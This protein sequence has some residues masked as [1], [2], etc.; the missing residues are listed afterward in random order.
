[1]MFAKPHQSAPGSWLGRLW[2]RLPGGGVL[3]LVL[4]GAL[5]LSLVACGGSVTRVSTFKAKR[6]IVFGDEYSLLDDSTEE[7]NARHYSINAL[8]D[9]GSTVQCASTS[10]RLWV[11]SLADL[12]GLTFAECN[13]DGVASASINAFMRAAYGA[14]AQDVYDQVVA[15]EEDLQG[16]FS[17][18]DMA[19]VLVGLHDVLEVFTNDD[20]YPTQ[21]DKEAE[22]TARGERVAQAVNRIAGHGTRVLVSTVA[23]VAYTPYAQALGADVQA[24]LKEMTKAFNNGL[25]AALLNDG[26]KIGLLY[27]N[28]LFDTYYK[29]S[30]YEHTEMACDVD[31]RNH[32]VHAA[33]LVQTQGDLLN[34]TTAT[35]SNGASLTTYLWADALRFNGMVIQ[36]QLGLKARSVAATNPF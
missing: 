25:S 33:G 7:G 4:A 5:A 19:T 23:D 8:D 29:S 2:H 18:H 34:C 32:D 22:L 9:G 16:G 15:F 30:K 31:H 10:Q 27:L 12:Y 26:T 35:L 36:H 1:M 14:K 11:Q 24:R 13:P 17:S 28:E 21:A 3:A 6:L 20:L